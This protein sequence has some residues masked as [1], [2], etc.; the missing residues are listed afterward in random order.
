MIKPSTSI[1]TSEA[2]LATEAKMI[3]CAGISAKFSARLN[4]AV[5]DVIA[6]IRR[7]LPWAQIAWTKIQ[8]G[9]TSILLINNIA[10]GNAPPENREPNINGYT[11]GS[12]SKITAPNIIQP[13]NVAV[14][15]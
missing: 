6:S 14:P 4:S 8:T 10:H 9:I 1:K 13:A 12:V 11:Y 3:P 7:S 5:I 15:N 2:R